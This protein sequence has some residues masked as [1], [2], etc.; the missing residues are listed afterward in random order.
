[1]VDFPASHVSFWEIKAR[2]LTHVLFW[3]VDALFVFLILPTCH[4]FWANGITPKPSFFSWICIRSSEKVPKR[5]S[6]GAIRN[7]RTNKSNFFWVKRKKTPKGSSFA[8]KLKKNEKKKKLTYPRE[9]LM[10]RSWIMQKWKF[11]LKKRVPIFRGTTCVKFCWAYR[12]GLISI[13]QGANV[14]I[15]FDPFRQF[16]IRWHSAGHP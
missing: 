3:E 2:S 8:T 5:F 16:P 13:S 6:H 15:G 7:Q 10:L 12:Q 9:K 14:S 4:R 1:M 11:P